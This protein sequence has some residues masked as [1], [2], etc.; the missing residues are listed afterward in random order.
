[1]HL[2]PLRARAGQTPSCRR[3]WPRTSQ[4]KAFESY[5]T[6]AERDHRRMAKLEGA[7]RRFEVKRGDRR[8][9]HRRLV[10]DA[11]SRAVVFAGQVLDRERGVGPKTRA[12]VGT[13]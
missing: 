5:G 10:A 12:R 13:A 2:Q 7:L 9:Q 4:I 1:R 8:L 11:E 6:A 3:G